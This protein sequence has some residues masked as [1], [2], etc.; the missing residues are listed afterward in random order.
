MRDKFWDLQMAHRLSVTEIYRN[1][2]TPHTWME[3]WVNGG[4][5]MFALSHV[6]TA[7]P[8]DFENIYNWLGNRGWLDMAYAYGFDEIKIGRFPE[9]YEHF[10]YL[11]DNFPGLKTM[12]T[13]ADPTFGSSE[14]T[15]YLRD[16]V[17]IW[18]PLTPSYDFD[19][20]RRLRAEGKQMWWYTCNVPLRPYAN[21]ILQYPTIESR[22]LLGAMSFKYEADGF[23]YYRVIGWGYDFDTGTWRNTAPITSGPY[24]N[25]DP[26]SGHGSSSTPGTLDG[27]GN[28]YYPG[29][30]SEGIMPSLRLA[31][32]RDGL[33]D[34]EY[35]AMLQEIVATF[36]R[37][38]P[39][40]PAVLAF[41]DEVAPLL[42]VPSSIVTSRTTYTFDS[43]ALYRLPS[44]ARPG[45]PRR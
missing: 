28:L 45:D 21:L 43:G 27:E 6:P 36:R 44:S 15:S 24:T 8:S 14:H 5:N 34:Y 3:Y 39:N 38:T 16:V 32:I 11:H 42:E 4:S 13:A 41:I 18:V 26:G 2:V 33:E 10:Q 17:D 12:T 1:T 37:C 40:D 7:R 19:E 29:P 30:P 25:W 20:A 31:N 22:L 35:L 23:L 9:M